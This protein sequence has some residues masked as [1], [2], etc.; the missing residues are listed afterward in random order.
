MRSDIESKI[1]TEKNIGSDGTVSTIFK[2]YVDKS[3]LG[4]WLLE[5]YLAQRVRV[6]ENFVMREN[7]KHLAFFNT[8]KDRDVGYLS[9]I[10]GYVGVLSLAMRMDVS[11]SD[12]VRN[13]IA[14]NVTMIL[15]YIDENGYTLFPYVREEDNVAADGKLFGRK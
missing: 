12:E 6:D 14:D 9:D 4:Q 10:Y 1:V 15:D 2:S 11:L 8:G 5:S 7:G 13:D 3:T